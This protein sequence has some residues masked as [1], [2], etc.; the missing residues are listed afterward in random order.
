MI[1]ACLGWFS[2]GPSGIDKGGNSLQARDVCFG[3]VSQMG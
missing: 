2:Q 3:K 1:L